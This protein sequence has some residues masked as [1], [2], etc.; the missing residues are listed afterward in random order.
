MAFKKVKQQKNK[1]ENQN[2]NQLVLN[3]SSQIYY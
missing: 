2:I 3:V 1:T